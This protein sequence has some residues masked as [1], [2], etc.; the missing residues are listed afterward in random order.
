MK[1]LFFFNLNLR[2][3]FIGHSLGGIIIRA[4]FDYLKEYKSCM[5]TFITLSSPHLGVNYNDSH[6]VDAGNSKK[7]KR[8][9]NK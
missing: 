6:L 4:A 3:S 5:H 1:F 2:I 8:I 7:K 9:K